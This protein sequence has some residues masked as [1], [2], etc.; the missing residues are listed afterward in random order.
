[1]ETLSDPSKIIEKPEGGSGQLKRKQ[2]EHKETFLPKKY[3]I[4]NS[5]YNNTHKV[6][7][8]EDPDNIINDI[9]LPFTQRVDFAK[10]YILKELPAVLR[11]KRKF[12][13]WVKLKISSSLKQLKYKQQDDAKDKDGSLFSSLM[14]SSFSFDNGTLENPQV[15]LPACSLCEERGERKLSGRLIPF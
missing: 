12:H 9:S 5:L 14:D 3:S 11:I 1:L 10:E 4:Y 6:N 13:S 2:N 8:Q 7:K 15:L